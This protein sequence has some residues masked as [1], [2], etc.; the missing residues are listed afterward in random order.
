MRSGRSVTSSG[1]MS[2]AGATGRTRYGVRSGR[3]GRDRAPRARRRA[4]ARARERPQPEPGRRAGVLRAGRPSRDGRGGVRGRS[5]RSGPVA[6]PE[7]PGGRRGGH[8]RRG[9]SQGRSA[10]RVG[11][12]EAGDARPGPG[13]RR[14][15]ESPTGSTGPAATDGARTEQ[16]PF[17]DEPSVRTARTHLDP[18]R[19]QALARGTPGSSPCSL[20][21]ARPVR[22]GGGCRE[23]GRTTRRW[24]CERTARPR[25]G[26]C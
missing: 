21:T 20:P 5:V 7:A 18:R 22:R 2:S 23:L 1:V 9:A 13:A 15:R 8:R 12:P 4:I 26:G 24:A 14:V 11:E 16:S 19:P 6:A 3:R 10:S 25:P 17:V